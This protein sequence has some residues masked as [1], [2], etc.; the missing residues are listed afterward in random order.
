MKIENRR[1]RGE[2]RLAVAAVMLSG[3][4]AL[5]GASAV[6]SAAVAQKSSS[7]LPSTRPRRVDADRQNE[8]PDGPLVRVG[9]MTDVTSISLGASSALVIRS[10]TAGDGEGQMIASAPLRVEVRR[11]PAAASVSDASTKTDAKIK[12]AKSKSSSHSTAAPDRASNQASNQ[13]TLHV[14]AIVSDRLLASSE[15][16]LIIT[17]ADESE[18]EP[19]NRQA[20]EA[21][22]KQANVVTQRRDEEK[23]WG[24]A[25]KID[26]SNDDSP[27]RQ[28]VRPARTDLPVRIAG[29][30]YRG[31][32]RLVLNR[33]G[34]I[35]V[36]NA[37]P[38]EYY[39]RGVVPMELPPG[40]YPEIEALKAQAVAARTYALAHRG[41]FRDEGYDLR[42]DARSQVYAGVTG[43]QPLTNRAV[44]ETRGRVA[45]YPADDGRLV[46][47]EAVYTANCGGRTENN[48]EVFGGKPLPYLRSVACSPDRLSLAGHDIV[49]AR[50]IESLTGAE[51]RLIAREVALFEVLGFAL[52]RR[53]TSNYLRSPVDSGEL[54]NWVERAA[55]LTGKDKPKSVRG[56]VTRILAFASLTASA[57]YGEN[58]ASVLLTPADIDYVLAGLGGKEAP[59]EARAAAAM[60]LK[61]GILRLHIEGALA[62]NAPVTRGY[63]I[64]TIA[65]A[66]Y[67]K[68]QP[69]Q[70]NSPRFQISSLKSQTAQASEDGRLIIAD[71][72]RTEAIA[73]KT[74]AGQAGHYISKEAASRKGGPQDRATQD[75]TAGFEIDKTAWLFRSLAGESYAVDRLTII[76]GE[77]VIYHVNAAG[78]VDFIEAAP[79][80]RGA[81]S[82]RFSSVA[83]WRERVAADDLRRRL[84]RSRVNVGDVEEIVPVE[85]GTSNRVLEV[86]IIGDEGRAR[87][88]GP[89]I[90]NALGL[91]ENLFVV[92]RESDSN[93]RVTAFVFTGRGWGH[94]V[95]LCQVGAYGLA[96]DG[97]SYTAILQ[98]YY[99][100]VRVQKIY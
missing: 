84:A 91:K 73:A 35:N 85:F 63:A 2:R 54:K 16:S 97:Y 27:R 64:E 88:R 86:E 67:L 65:R 42:D 25:N 93:G 75:E 33:R 78:R 99:T 98:K 11:L 56:D 66:F 32:I 24:A 23:L 12:T 94:G 57:L 96:K 100:G 29:K 48:E 1:R 39:L 37:L 36:V 61:D 10:S 7:E 17:A 51:G 45:L 87:L 92:D 47:I 95:G 71:K 22:R 18:L 21:K 80:E 14:V 43:E 52:P 89:Q 79:A 72:S 76:G 53:V 9:I 41:Q 44:E 28:I 5:D 70:A 74:G 81:S 3:C 49:S 8:T 31:E 83:Q 30:E 90:R 6:A 82:D 13:P 26:A 46:P 20:D 68:M 60:L 59:Q 15:D 62:S 34:K 55:E 4:L 38:M 50:T 58:R 69:V 77:R 40:P 19:Q